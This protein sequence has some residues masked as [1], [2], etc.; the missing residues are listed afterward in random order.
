MK[1]LSKETRECAEKIDLEMKNEKL[2]EINFELLEACKNIL[3]SD[4]DGYCE[5]DLMMLRE[6]KRV[7]A[8]AGGRK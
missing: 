5:L 7:I 3:Q 1:K 6:I 2:K 4:K 8:K